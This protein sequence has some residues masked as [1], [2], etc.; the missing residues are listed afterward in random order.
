[1]IENWEKLGAQFFTKSFGVARICHIKVRRILLAYNAPKNDWM[2]KLNQLSKQNVIQKQS[3]TATRV[4]VVT[5]AL[6]ILA[7]KQI[8][9]RDFLDSKTRTTT[10]TCTRF[11][12]Y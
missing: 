4:V 9:N 8:H 10:S 3:N 11:S 2:N 5:Q 7:G 12:Q 1:M 6:W